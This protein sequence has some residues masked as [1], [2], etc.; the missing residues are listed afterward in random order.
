MKKVICAFK[1][2]VG[3]RGIGCSMWR[4]YIYHNI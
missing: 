2:A 1:S 4:W 3:V